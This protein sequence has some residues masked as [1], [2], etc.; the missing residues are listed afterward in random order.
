MVEAKSAEAA[1]PAD[2]HSRN[3]L[4]I[5][6]VT[7]FIDLLGFAIVLPLLPR[8]GEYFHANGAVLG[9]LMASFS[10]MQFIFSP[11]WGRVSD[12]V[13]RRPIL[14]LGLA[15]STASYAVF[16][17]GLVARSGVANAGP[18]TAHLALH[19]P[20]RCG[21]RRRHDFDGPGLHRRHDQ[22]S[23]AGPRHGTDW[24]RLR[25]WLHL[26]SADR[27]GLRLQR[28]DRASQPGRRLRGL[29]ACPAS[30]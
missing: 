7:V 13:G 5:V 20:H 8:Y 1:K 30:P 28:P 26:W 29:G 18:G 24:R 2:G 23:A 12:H 4:G 9:L 15:G 17:I 27:C 14:I 6:F 21:D 16:G 3:S 25:H 10:A 22:S 19:H 11:I